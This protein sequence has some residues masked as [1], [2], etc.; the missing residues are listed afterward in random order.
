M[1]YGSDRLLWALPLL[2]L[3]F[4]GCAS[5][6][7]S[8]QD[9]AM[10]DPLANGAGWALVVRSDGPIWLGPDWWRDQ[11]VDPSTL[12][13]DVDV[14]ISHHGERVPHLV[15][16]GPAG[17]G[18]FFL[19]RTV[20]LSET[21]FS[22]VGPAGGY[23]LELSSPVHD[24][25]FPGAPSPSV[26][27]EGCQTTSIAQ[28]SIGP[29]LVFRST[30][31][32]DDVWLWEALRPGDGLTV[33]TALTD[34]V[35]STSVTVTTSVWG[36]SSMPA[37]PDHHLR[38]VWNGD[39][40]GDHFWDG[41]APEVWEV[42]VPGNGGERVTLGLSAPGGTDAPVEL[43][44]LDEI[45]FDWHQHL[46][47]DPDRW[48]TWLAGNEATACFEGPVADGQEGYV[49][50]L[51]S[52]AGVVRFVV[53]EVN[54][55]TGQVRVAQT[56]GDVGW[57]G[58]PWM[59]APPDLIRPRE[60]V[61]RDRLLSADYVIVASREFHRSVEPLAEA[62]RASG[63]AV[64]VVTPQGVYDSYG[65]GVPTAE[66]IQA[67]VVD[68]ATNG[69][70]DALLLIGDAS[71][72]S[73]DLWEPDARSLPTG[74]V[75]TSHVGMT[76]SDFALAT[77]GGD[78]P[79]VAVGRLPVSTYNELTV[80]VKK[81]LSWEP[82][83]RLL[84]VSDDE[85]AFSRMTDQL[86]ELRAP[87][88]V[89]GAGAED[90]RDA[91][92]QWLEDGPGTLVYTGHGSMGL[93]GDEKLLVLEDGENWRQ[94][95]VVVAWSCLCAS[96]AHPTYASLAESWLLAPR[97]VV[98]VVGP[99]GETTTAEQTDMALALQSALVEGDTLGGAMLSAWR[100]SQSENSKHGFVL[101]GDPGLQP[102]PVD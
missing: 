93:L 4:T 36:Q 85:P 65:S 29:D 78:E 8:P 14:L 18:V 66:S 2:L 70:L 24:S 68:L 77:G 56:A 26:S 9:I 100:A 7:P 49:A 94:P 31:P 17:P 97:G 40:V 10:P 82:N 79:L 45:Q 59:A 43:T 96:F 27:D 16:D 75:T 34:I 81:T 101:L 15:V 55:E 13:S 90:G 71:A 76:A 3:I 22:M 35:P 32:L 54:R 63:L 73:E 51:E 72:S 69:N 48:R 50:V 89:V 53:P 11:G 12:L 46:R 74:W 52:P 28:S 33:T 99:T 1:S 60:M 30:A 23:T 83:H 102:M 41:N 86:G 62:R 58:L 88:L 87:D 21:T 44:W 92:L 98:A 42:M 38:M 37:N 95:T 64:G 84:M 80:V 20:A 91:I 47:L 67:L 5:V 25:Q 19:G 61:S 39:V 57:I 6:V